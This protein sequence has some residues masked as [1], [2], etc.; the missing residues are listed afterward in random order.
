MPGCPRRAWPVWSSGAR[1]LI[2]AIETSRRRPTMEFAVAADEALGTG[3]LLVDLLREQQIGEHGTLLV[4]CPGR[5]MRQQA[6]RLRNF[7]AVSGAWPA[8]DREIMREPS[9]QRADWLQR[10][11]LVEEFVAVRMEPTGGT[12]PP[13][14]PTPSVSFVDRREPALRRPIGG[15]AVLDRAAWPSAGGWLSCRHL[16]APCASRSKPESMSRLAAGLSL[17]SCPG[18]EQVALSGEYRPGACH[19]RPGDGFDLT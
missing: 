17:P 15:P 11:A 9:S 6:M 14:R 4:R 19:G 7:R 13:R 16:R 10:D 3:G 5:D 1:R 18:G 8:P 12:V 2:A